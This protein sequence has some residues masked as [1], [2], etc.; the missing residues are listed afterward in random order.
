MATMYCALCN[1]PVEANRRIGAGTVVLA[2]ITGGLW[3]LAIPFYPK[4]CAICESTA[5]TQTGPS[6]GAF[7]GKMEE[8][9]QRLSLAE[10]ELEAAHVEIDRLKAEQQFYRQLLGAPKDPGTPRRE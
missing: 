9:E 3:V 1:R 6:G 5:V 10:G 4:R 7:G 8:F 2:V